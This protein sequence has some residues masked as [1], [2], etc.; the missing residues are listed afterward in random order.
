MQAS[1]FRS[2]E[3]PLEIWLISPS[4]NLDA[5]LQMKLLTFDSKT[6]Y[7]NGAAL[8]VWVSSDYDGIDPTKATWL[9][10][11]TCYNC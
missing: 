3:N 8:S 1:A 2:G 7:N 4:I 11:E 10:V 5:V 9:K 6:G